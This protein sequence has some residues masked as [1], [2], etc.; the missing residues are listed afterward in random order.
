MGAL[1]VQQFGGRVARSAAESND[2][3]ADGMRGISH[4]IS[5][6]LKTKRGNG[7]FDFERLKLVTPD[8]SR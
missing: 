7:C 8:R 5:T 4:C 3:G 2:G 6:L 1:I